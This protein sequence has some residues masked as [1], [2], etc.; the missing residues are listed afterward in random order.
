MGRGRPPDA[1]LCT[2]LPERSG[3]GRERPRGTA[4]GATASGGR[5]R[6]PADHPRVGREGAMKIRFLAGT[7]LIGLLLVS[8]RSDGGL[9][10]RFVDEAGG[11]VVFTDNPWQFEVYR[12]QLNEEPDR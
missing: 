7:V 9:I 3:A 12:R 10:Y 8:S 2:L 6:R 11:V 4:A 1:G 5:R